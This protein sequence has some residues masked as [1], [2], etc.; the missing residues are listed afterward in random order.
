LRQRTLAL[1]SSA[2]APSLALDRSAA[3]LASLS[4]RRFAPFLAKRKSRFEKNQTSDF[5]WR[6][7]P[8]R[9]ALGPVHQRLDWFVE[10]QVLRAPRVSVICGLACRAALVP[11]AQKQAVLGRDRCRNE[12]GNK[13]GIGALEAGCARTLRRGERGIEP[14][15]DAAFVALG[16]RRDSKFNSDDPPRARSDGP[17]SKTYVGERAAR[18]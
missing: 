10:S 7:P 8:R 4:S 15:P 11:R 6:G 9:F 12:L 18:P 16:Y 13:R 17:L 2:A 5:R 1:L 14:A 3:Q